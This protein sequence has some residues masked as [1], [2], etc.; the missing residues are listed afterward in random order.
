MSFEEKYKKEMDSVAFSADYEIRLNDTLKSTEAPKKTAFI[1]PKKK[2]VRLLAALVSVILILSVSTVAEPSISPPEKL[3][4]VF[5]KSTSGWENRWKRRRTFP[6]TFSCKDV[7][8]ED[9][10]LTILGIASGEFLNECEGFSADEAKDYFVVALYEHEGYLT[11]ENDYNIKVSPFIFGR[12]PW[13]VNSTTLCTDIRVA[14]KNG[15][16]YYLFDTSFLERFKGKTIYFAAYEGD[17]PTEKI[18]TMKKK[19]Y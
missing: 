15:V 3:D 13:E 17:T 14:A 7:A 4:E 2:I 11:I 18:F 9:I 12:E 1:R 10:S 8:Y 5:Q 16:L 6:M 19:Y